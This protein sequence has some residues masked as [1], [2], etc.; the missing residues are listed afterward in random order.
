M[1]SQDFQQHAIATFL[2]QLLRDVKDLKT[3]VKELEK[4]NLELLE[5][6]VHFAGR[7]T[8]L[9]PDKFFA[10]YVTSIGSD[11]TY[12]WA[13]RKVPSAI[14][15]LSVDTRASTPFIIF[16]PPGHACPIPGDV[17]IA[18][19]TGI[20]SGSVITYEDFIQH[21]IYYG[22][23]KGSSPWAPTTSNTIEVYAGTGGSE[24]TK[25]FCVRVYNFVSTINS[26]DDVLVNNNDFSWY[27]SA[28]K[29][30]PSTNVTSLLTVVTTV[31]YDTT[32]HKLQLQSATVSV[33][34]MSAISG[35]TDIT[36]ATTC[37][38]A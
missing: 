31:R 19:H 29:F 11:Q 4:E 9:N 26:N 28:L 15:F 27:V 35:W 30:P 25:N 5:P 14:G 34:S 21:G 38:T 8:V 16:V 2:A 13:Y 18:H 37:T 33:T 32:T 23:Y 24:S 22:K 10:V 20:T 12:F 3:R 7:G 6:V 1:A 36:Q 17:T